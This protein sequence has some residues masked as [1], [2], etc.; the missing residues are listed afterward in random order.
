MQGCALTGATV[1]HVLWASKNLCV[2]VERLAWGKVLDQKPTWRCR[3]KAQTSEEP[4][5]W[6]K[7][8]IRRISSK[9]C[10][11]SLLQVSMLDCNPSLWPKCSHITLQDRVHSRFGKF[12]FIWNVKWP[13][14]SSFS[15][16]LVIRLSSKVRVQPVC[17]PL[18]YKILLCMLSKASKWWKDYSKI[19]DFH[20]KF[21][22]NGWNEILVRQAVFH[23][24]N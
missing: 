22:W 14:S 6:R 2:C 11:L 15:S 16:C 10:W 4:S 8:L 7:S 21:W 20:I 17:D 1:R 3:S 18:I 13:H 23:M 24:L 5:L 19:S 9:V 12:L